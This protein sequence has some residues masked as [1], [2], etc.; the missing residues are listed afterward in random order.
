MDASNCTKN[1]LFIDRYRDLE[2]RKA[3]AIRNG[4]PGIAVNG[5]TACRAVNATATGNGD[6]GIY[7]LGSAGCAVEASTADANLLNGICLESPGTGAVVG[8]LLAM[9]GYPGI[10]VNWGRRVLI[11]RNL[12][13]SNRLAGVWLEGT[14]PCVVTRNATDGY[15]AGLV[16]RNTT[17]RPLTRGNRWLRPRP[18]DGGIISISS[19][20]IPAL[21]PQGS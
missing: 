17:A 20:F 1:G 5:S 16:V 13:C 19:L 21:L 4:Y 8:C 2:L 9:N 10:A 11:S 14:W 6:A 3:A 15:G 12:L 18:L 7:L